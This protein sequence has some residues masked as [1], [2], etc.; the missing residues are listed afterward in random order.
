VDDRAILSIEDTGRG[1]AA[2]LIPSIM[3]RGV[4]YGKTEG[5]GLGLFHAKTQVES[6]D[7]ML[8]IESTPDEGT[9]VKIE[10]P[11]VE[12]PSWFLNE[13]TLR[14]ATT[15]V[16]VDDD[17]SIHRVWD[18]RFLA[19][20][21]QSETIKLLHFS[22]PEELANWHRSTHE[23]NVFYLVDYEFS[24]H[25]QNG[26]EIIETMKI[27]GQSALVTSRHEQREIIERC[28]QLGIRIIPKALA[29]FVPIKILNKEKDGKIGQQIS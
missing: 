25:K 11:S 21:L 4:S 28:S 24:G 17:P 12:A 2:N 6:W 10:L 8:S 1:I 20:S 5:S 27:Q 14:S 29:G 26:L 3:D 9:T 19:L 15:L 18:M 13:I 7:G 23:L 22:N 16:V